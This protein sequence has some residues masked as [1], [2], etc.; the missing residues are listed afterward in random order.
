M[1][2]TITNGTSLKQRLSKSGHMHQ[3]HRF[4]RE[5]I[6]V[7]NWQLQPARHARKYAT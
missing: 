3:D 7:T 5:F 4:R 2:L 6:F 1:D